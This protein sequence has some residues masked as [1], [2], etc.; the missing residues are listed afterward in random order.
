MQ[1]I[2]IK[3]VQ[4][5]VVHDEYILDEGDLPAPTDPSELSPATLNSVRDI[6]KDIMALHGFVLSN[7]PVAGSTEH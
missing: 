4:V 5:A 7:I 6:F 3:G 1:I 2:L